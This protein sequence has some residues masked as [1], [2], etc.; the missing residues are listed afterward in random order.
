M[1]YA[2]KIFLHSLSL[3]GSGDLFHIVALGSKHHESHA[4]H[5]VGTGSEYLKVNIASCDMEFHLCTLRTTYPIALCLLK[6]VSP[7]DSVK[8]FKKTLCVSRYTQTPL[9]HQLLLHRI[10]ATDRKTL[11]HLIVG[12]HCAELRTPVYHRI[13]EISYAVIHQS[14]ALLLLVH[15]VPLVGGK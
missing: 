1:L 3:F 14:V 11:A 12:K 10:T 15:S 6:R 4:K 9:I 13:A 5:S 8:T 7:V 2:V